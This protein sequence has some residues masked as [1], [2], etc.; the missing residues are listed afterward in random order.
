MSSKI[1]ELPELE[2]RIIENLPMD[3]N[4]QAVINQD[5]YIKTVYEHGMKRRVDANNSHSPL[6]RKSQ[7]K[8]YSYP[9]NLEGNYQ[10]LGLDNDED[11]LNSNSLVQERRNKGKLQYKSI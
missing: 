11:E 4:L 2:R 1:K 8:Q 9:Q 10:Q 6:L 7:M 3:N 5:E